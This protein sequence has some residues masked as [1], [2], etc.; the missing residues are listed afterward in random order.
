MS[1]FRDYEPKDD[2][3]SL[4]FQDKQII[5]DLLESNKLTEDER[6]ALDH[7]YYSYNYA[8]D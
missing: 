7:L 5:K 3:R 4:T 2:T 8:T 6:E 1:Q